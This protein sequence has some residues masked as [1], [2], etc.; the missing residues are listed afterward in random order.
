MSSVVYKFLCA[1]CNGCYVGRTHVYFN[2]RQREHFETDLNSAIYKH[3]AENQNCI[4]AKDFNAFSILDHASTRY[5]LALKEAMHIK[6]LNPK[7]N[8]Q[9]R[10]EIIRLLI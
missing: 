1:I 5:E 9:K 4:I 7:L 6:W 10:H 8:E 2:T 3:F